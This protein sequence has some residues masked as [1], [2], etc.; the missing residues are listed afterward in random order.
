MTEVEL[1]DLVT[2]YNKLKSV[3]RPLHPLYSRISHALSW[4]NTQ[5]TICSLVVTTTL[6]IYPAYLQ[7]ALLAALTGVFSVSYMGNFSQNQHSRT[8]PL[9]PVNFINPIYYS[10]EPE[11][12]KKSREQTIEDYKCM[13]QEL[14]VLLKNV[15]QIGDKLI[16][17]VCWKDFNET[18]NCLVIA[19]FLILAPSVIPLNILLLGVVL[20]LFCCNKTCYNALR[21]LL[22]EIDFK[23]KVA[24]EQDYE[25][26]ESDGEFEDSAELSNQPSLHVPL[27]P[28]QESQDDIEEDGMSPSALS[29]SRPCT[30]CSSTGCGEVM[31]GFCGRSYC[32]KCCCNTVVKASLGVTNPDTKHD[33][34]KV[35]AECAL[36]LPGTG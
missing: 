18:R 7:F 4:R 9:N 8:N 5:F 22:T 11:S 6:L 12:S 35:C 14:D 20:Y 31:C 32:A 33:L 26:A 3:C 27:D 36:Y 13:L 19:G 15:L 34:V 23:C 17:V 2:N 24:L 30:N 16:E 25:R 1:R 28:V 21:G 10:L 29:C